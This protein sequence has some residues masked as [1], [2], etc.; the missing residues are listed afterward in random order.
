M[1]RFV[2]YLL[3]GGTAAALNWSSRFLFSIWLSYA[4]SIVCA[5]FVG[6]VCGFVLMRWLVFDGAGKPAMP[7][8]GMYVV[9]NALALM[10][11]LVVSLTL[12]KWVIPRIGYSANPE[13]P[14]HL[15]G[16]MVPAVTSYF[17]H[18][19]FTFR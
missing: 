4:A 15:M 8:A 3:A 10:Q 18:K 11:T 6:L 12:A 9:V 2:A 7:Q 5:F 14:A 19:F 17:G 1:Q 16:V 13:G